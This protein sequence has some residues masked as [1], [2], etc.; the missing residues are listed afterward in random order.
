MNVTP[1]FDKN[2]EAFYEGYR[3]IINQGGTSSSK[4]FS[5]L[6]L[7]LHIAIKYPDTSI[8]V[9]SETMPH[10]KRGA[11]KDFETILKAD[12]LYRDK[13]INRTD[14]QYFFNSSTIEFFSADS[15]GKVTGPRRN[16]LY[17]NECNNIPYDR[18]IEMELRTDGTIFYD[19]NPVQDFWISDKVLSLPDSE[20]KLIKSNYLDND[21]L[22]DSIK[23]EIQMRADRDPNFKKIHIDVEFG[24]YEGLIF[25]GFEMVDEMPGEAISYGMD[26]GFSNDPSTI[27]DV[28]FNNG[29]IFADLLLYRTEMTNQDIIRFLKELNV[30]RKEIIADCAEPKSI[31]EIELAGFHIIPSIKGEDSI[32]TGIDLIKQYKLNVTKR[33]VE[34]IKEL[35]NYQWAK[36]RNGVTLNKP[37]DMF[38]HAIDALRYNVA[39][40]KM[41]AVKAPK[42]WIPGRRY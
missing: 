36:D 40:R 4:T 16:I 1:V 2:I 42:V 23:R 22:S 20:R 41:A 24:V 5:I 38:N 33:S 12:G 31:R 15:P 19:Y 14:H 18:V 13:H 30:G 29:E 6:Q 8:S 34:L 10:L 35:R 25:T 3:R 7:L 27:V 9:V 21:S 37:V 26:F 17:L 28:R 32:R 11:I 39:H